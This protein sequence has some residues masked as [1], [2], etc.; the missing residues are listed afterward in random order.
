[1]R[2]TP[3]GN[4]VLSKTPGWQC[5][6]CKEKQTIHSS[7]LCRPCNCAIDS[8]LDL[9]VKQLKEECEKSRVRYL[10]AKLALEKV[11]LD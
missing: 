7:S 1:M 8:L 10:Q 5:P 11:C 2:R 4:L 6:L 9:T 3:A